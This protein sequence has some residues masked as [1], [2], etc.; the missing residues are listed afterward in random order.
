MAYT[1]STYDS[2][3]A[4]AALSKTFRRRA[5]A[6]RAAKAM[7]GHVEVWRSFWTRVGSE[8]TGTAHT[9]IL[10]VRDGRVTA[11]AKTVAA[12]CE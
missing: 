3:G 2:T 12:G 1:I 4:P 5:D 9:R 11:R 10:V 8:I 7:S 6:E